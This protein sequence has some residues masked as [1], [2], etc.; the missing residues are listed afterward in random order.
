M[1]KSLFFVSCFLL[2]GACHARSLRDVA[3]QPSAALL[4]AQAH[5]NHMSSLRSKVALIILLCLGVWF[6]LLGHSLRSMTCHRVSLLEVQRVHACMHVCMCAC[7][8]VYVC[9]AV[10]DCAHV[11]VAW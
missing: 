11:F 8:Y 4:D 1:P 5:A 2:V 9:V 3:A 6:G 7:A 10:C